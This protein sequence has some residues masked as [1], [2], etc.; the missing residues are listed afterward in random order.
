MSESPE[1]LSTVEIIHG[2]DVDAPDASV[3]WLHGLGA[4]AHDFEP[5]IPELGLDDSVTIR[6]VFPNAPQIPVALNM[7]MVMRA[8]YD[9]NAADWMERRDDVPGVLRSAQHVT[10]LIE[11]EV[12]RGVEARNI[13]L[14]GFS[15]GG[16]MALHTALRH[17][18]K[19]RGVMVLSGYL[20]CA[21]T[22]EQEAAAINKD[23]PVFLAHGLFDPMVPIDRAK[24]MRQTLKDMGHK[25]EWH[26]YPMEHQVS[27]EE[28]RHIGEWLQRV[29]AS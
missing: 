14:A 16:A 11:H 17:P 7:G 20:V 24:A 25:A 21:D 12:A 3:I 22:L 8:W 29:L 19:L 13:I 23:I 2:P 18:E 4:D 6:F 15:Q 27:G 26:E 9:I 1:R 28:C 5:I 10:A